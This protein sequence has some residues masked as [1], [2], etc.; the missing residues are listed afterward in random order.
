M[1]EDDNESFSNPESSPSSDT[2][3]T[4]EVEPSKESYAYKQLESPSMIRVLQLQPGKR[5]EQINIGLIHFPLDVQDCI[6]NALSYNWG[7]AYDVKELRVLWTVKSPIKQPM[8]LDALRARFAPL[9]SR[10]CLLLSLH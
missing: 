10:A 1:D 8:A 5:G 4:C 2:D 3:K 6:Y 7:D 9:T